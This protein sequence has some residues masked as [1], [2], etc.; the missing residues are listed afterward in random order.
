MM[1]KGVKLTLCYQLNM[2]IIILC[3]KMFSYCV[4]FCSTNCTNLTVADILKEHFLAFPELKNV[5]SEVS[6]K[7]QSR[8]E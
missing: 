2:S 7:A 3:V 4:I 6:C 8:M 1:V 5:D